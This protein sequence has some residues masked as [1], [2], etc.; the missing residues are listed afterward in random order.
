MALKEIFSVVRKGR[1]NIAAALAVTL[2][3]AAC[4][5]NNYPPQSYTPTPASKGGTYKVGNPYKV[6]GKW[7]TPREDPYYDQTG[8]ASWYGKK[9]HGR[10]TANGETYNMNGFSAAH[11]TLPMPVHVKVTNLDNGRTLVVRVN[12]RGPFVHGRIIDLSRRAAQELG[13]LEQGT[14]RIRVQV[15]RDPVGERFVV[16]KGVT[17]PA[18]RKSVVAAPAKEV[19][20]KALD[21][22]TGVTTAPLRAPTI[23]TA[24]LSGNRGR[25][26]TPKASADP[27]PSLLY[28]QAGA[29]SDQDNAHKL[30]E[31]L[32]TIGSVGIAPVQVGDTQYYRVRIGPI[33]SIERADKTL[34][35]L[36]NNGHADARIVVDTEAGTCRVC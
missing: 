31:E 29:F 26:I 12:D 4:T 32:G 36:I 33:E 21:A 15:V 27:T 16:A 11:K 9:F 1:L 3:L 34:T 28:V 2:F 8:I 25:G 23:K 20:T 7:Y 17:S 22:P 6:L 14:T 19:Q 18:E 24:A 5:G 13:F 30:R 10:L 35:Q